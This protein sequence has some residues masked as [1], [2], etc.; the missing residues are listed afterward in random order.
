MSDFHSAIARDAVAFEAAAALHDVQAAALERGQ[1]VVFNTVDEA[2]VRRSRY[3]SIK[4][5]D[6]APT[7]TMLANSVEYSPSKYT[8]AKLGFRDD[9]AVIVFTPMQSWIDAGLA[10]IDRI[11]WRMVIDGRQFEI[12]DNRKHDPLGAAYL[13]VVLGGKDTE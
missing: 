1:E 3:N 13:Y 9:T 10:D 7:F 6:I 5:R 8:L 4:A 2:G 12:T 11:R